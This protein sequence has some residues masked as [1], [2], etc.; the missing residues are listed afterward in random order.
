MRD[1]ELARTLDEQR[2][3]F[4]IS[5][6]PA[7]DQAA[8]GLP[9]VTGADVAATYGL[10]VHYT[11]WQYLVLMM[12]D[13]EIRARCWLTPTAYAECMVPYNLG[14]DSPREVCLLVDVSSLPILWGPGVTPPSARNPSIWRGGGIEFYSPHP[15]P[16]SC[17]TEVI[18]LAPCGDEHP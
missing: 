5:S 9:P 12:Q 8:R 17:V 3:K 11:Q 14:L 18:E 10:L 13:R 1:D 6:L 2:W 7:A 16:F 15:I 4:P